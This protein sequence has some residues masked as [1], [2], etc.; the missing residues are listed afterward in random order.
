M[1]PKVLVIVGPTAS[2]KSDLGVALAKKLLGEIVSADSRQVY[3]G[4]NHGTGK[5]I[6]SEMQGIPHHLLDIVSPKIQFTATQY[7]ELALKALREIVARR[8]FP[9]IVGGTGFYID[10]VTCGV[11][12]PEV[13]PNKKLR[14]KLSKLSVEKLFDML[15]AKDPNR[16]SLIDSKNKVRLVR[17]LEIISTLG[18]VPKIKHVTPEYEFVFVGLNPKDLDERIERRLKKRLP[19]IIT[20]VKKL[21][22]EGLTWKRLYELG[23]EYRYVSL[24]LRGVMNKKEMNMEL[25]KE[26][27]K[28]AKRQMT[29]F[30]RNK[31]ITWLPDGGNASLSTILKLLGQQKRVQP[32]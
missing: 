3:K 9:I 17:A 7:R 19:K 27:R 4:L 23:L 16:A 13:P 1:K 21:R 5:I 24:H 2:G 28:Y 12:Y 31:S 8:K 26:I 15:K 25:L 14:D 6:R 30:K 22:S 10:T 20:E 18:S 29:W 32:K 11:L